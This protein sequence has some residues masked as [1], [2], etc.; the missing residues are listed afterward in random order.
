MSAAAACGLLFASHPELQAQDLR[1]CLAL[2][3]RDDA[4]LFAAIDSVLA[5]RVQSGFARDS[6]P[7]IWHR[8]HLSPFRHLQTS[9]V[10]N[11]FIM[12]LSVMR[13][14]WPGVRIADSSDASGPQRELSPGG[15][16]IVL[17]P[18]D[19]LGERMARVRFA[20]FFDRLTYG[21]EWFVMVAYRDGR[22][23]AIEIK[24]GWAN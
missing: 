4:V 21:E 16:V 2:N 20:I 24:A 5:E 17:A 3:C 23:R 15:P 22:W 10:D 6:A 9:A 11:V 1:G 18:V 7:R 13:R 12:D 14:N 19:W 8:V